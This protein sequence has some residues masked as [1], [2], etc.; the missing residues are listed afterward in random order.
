[1]NIISFILKTK[2]PFSLALLAIT[3]LAVNAEQLFL[4]SIKANHYAYDAVATISSTPAKISFNSWPSGIKEKVALAGANIPLM[5]GSKR[6]T[7][8]DSYSVRYRVNA[9][10]GLVADFYNQALVNQGWKA[11]TQAS[12][13]VKLEK[14][15]IRYTENPLSNKTD[16]AYAYTPINSAVLGVKIAEADAPLSQPIQIGR[17]HV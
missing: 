7:F 6:I 16:I 12:A 11:T 17:A 9:S 14:L 4:Q 3:A 8:N 13:N 10:A 1:M 15:T 5:P 2:I